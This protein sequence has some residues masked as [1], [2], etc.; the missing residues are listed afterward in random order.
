MLPSLDKPDDHSCG[1]D[2]SQIALNLLKEEE[3]Y[4]QAA[5]HGRAHA[6]HCDLTQ[7]IHE[8]CIA[9]LT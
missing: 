8:E 6:F 1:L 2:L 5:K 7:I 9:Y 3:L 4:C